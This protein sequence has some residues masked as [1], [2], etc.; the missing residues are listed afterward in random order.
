MNRYEEVCA[1][2]DK[3]FKHYCGDPLRA[4]R[5]GELVFTCTEC[6]KDKMGVNIES[7]VAHCFV[8]GWKGNAVTF[9]MLKENLDKTAATNKGL[10]IIESTTTP[11]VTMA[12]NRRTDAT[13]GNEKVFL[14]IKH[15]I[16]MAIYKML[17]QDYGARHY[18]R[19]TMFPS[20]SGKQLREVDIVVSKYTNDIATQLRKTFPDDML[21]LCPGFVIDGETGLAKFTLNHHILFPYWSADGKY[22]QAYNGRAKT[23]KAG[24][25]RYR[26]L[27]D[28]RKFLYVP[29]GVDTRTVRVITEGEKKA[30]LATTLGVPTVSVA[31]INCYDTPDTREFLTGVPGLSIFIVFDRDKGDD[32]HVSSAEHRL[33]EWLRTEC[34]CQGRIVNL[35]DGYKMD[36]FIIEFGIDAFKELL[37]KTDDDYGPFYL[38]PFGG[39]T[40]RLEAHYQKGSAPISGCLDGC[41]HEP[42]CAYEFQFP[43]SDSSNSSQEVHQ[44]QQED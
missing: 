26:W 17:V 2:I 8:C 24:Y 19:K 7:H 4:G 40:G 22:I 23:E 1:G 39:I 36:D 3:V 6:G 9:I 43:T 29:R 37:R 28:E 11:V 33:D 12:R 35:P 14:P 21:Q 20:L 32:I 38:Y 15:S 13:A 42:H 31:G 18:W 30:I 10:Q 27:I 34:G 25:P 16:Y 5:S 41:E 44:A